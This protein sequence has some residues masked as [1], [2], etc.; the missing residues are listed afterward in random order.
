M[1][2]YSQGLLYHHHEQQTQT[3]RAELQ[4]TVRLLQGT[5]QLMRYTIL[6]VRV[7]LDFKLHYQSNPETD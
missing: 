7:D 2:R 1:Y 3:S 5:G 4:Q 6:L